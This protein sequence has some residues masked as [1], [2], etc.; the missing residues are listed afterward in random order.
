MIIISLYQKF[1]KK[2]WYKELKEL[3]NVAPKVKI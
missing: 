3:A 1:K 2:R